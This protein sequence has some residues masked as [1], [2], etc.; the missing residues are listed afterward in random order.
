MYDV[1]YDGL[2]NIRGG[3]MSYSY[4]GITPLLQPGGKPANPSWSSRST[5]FF[6]FNWFGTFLPGQKNLKLA[7]ASLGAQNVAQS[8]VSCGPYH[9]SRNL[10]TVASKLLL[11]WASDKW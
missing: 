5:N 11:T 1:S 2:F 10:A 9:G 6:R 3:G 7:R 4:K 8:H